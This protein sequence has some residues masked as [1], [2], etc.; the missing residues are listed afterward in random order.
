MNTLNRETRHLQSRHYLFNDKFK[1]ISSS[2]VDVLS[3]IKEEEKSSD[4]V[5]I[6]K[7]LAAD[8]FG[9]FANG[10]F[11]RN[12]AYYTSKIRGT[13]LILASVMQ[14]DEIV[15][16]TRRFYLIAFLFAL[17]S[18]AVLAYVLQIIIIKHTRPLKELSILSR[19]IEKGKLHTE[20]PEF[21]N[22]EETEQLAKTLRTVQGR[23]QKYV[24]SLHTT[25]KEKRALTKDLSIAEKIQND[26]LPS[27]D[28]TLTNVPQID[29]YCKLIPAKG[30]AGDFYDY[31]FI[32]D[33]RLFFVLGDVS[34][35]GIPAAL[36]MVK[37]MTLMQVEA[38]KNSDPGKIFTAVNEQ[39][40]FRNDE[41]MFVTA[42]CGVVN[43]KTGE[44]AL[45][46][47][48]HHE[49]L[50]NFG[51]HNFNYTLLTKN[52]PLGILIGGKPYSS[53][54]FNL[55]KGD[56]LILYSDGLPEASSLSGKMLG[57]EPV[58]KELLES[59]DK[60]I[61]I[62]AKKIWNLYERFTYHA[63][64]NDDI[65]IFILRYFGDNNDIQKD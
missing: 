57:H 15:K 50:T 55:K 27:P 62:L 56:T 11:S 52:L 47:A 25:L 38:K 46:D 20:I 26:M 12:K 31:F 65:S 37:A 21:H 2:S 33:D 5:Q 1:S 44:L 53:T 7:L 14:T 61:T 59:G 63:I 19:Q 49:P 13:N 3:I 60:E 17:I 24:T 64:G 45:C 6:Q 51:S 28:W 41:G 23:M 58:E 54:Y 42:V 16:Q 30:V 48:G 43:I 36:F 22:N 35:K 18:F 32:D 8:K 34:G 40:T 29:I 39:L 9:Y 4:I 10:N